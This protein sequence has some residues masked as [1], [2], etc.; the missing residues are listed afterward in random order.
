MTGTAGSRAILVTGGNGFIGSALLRAAV[1]RGWRA[2]G[3]GR[4][5]PATDGTEWRAY[6]LA[7]QELDDALFRGVDVVV[8]AAYVKRDYAVNVAGSRLLLAS[9]QRSG[10]RQFVFL[11]SLAAHPSAL[12]T[13]GKQKYEL[14]RAFEASDALCVRPGLVI[15]GGGLFGA[16]CDYLRDHSVVPLIGGGAQPVQTVSIDDLTDTICAAIEREATGTFTVAE[17]EPVAYH[18]FYAALAACMERHVRFVP[19]PFWSADLAVRVA[20]TLG[21]ALPIDRDN[22]LGLR[23]MRPDTGPW[24]DPPGRRVTGYRENLRRNLGVILSGAS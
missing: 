15:G 7:W 3:C 19:I 10:V 4:K 2:I 18:V 17:R 6:D 22:L 9:A 14:E 20:G 1:A 24:L 21:V 13:Y 11:S 5:Q 16:M 23:A 12:S 8:H